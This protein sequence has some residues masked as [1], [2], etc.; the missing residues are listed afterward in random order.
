METKRIRISEKA[1]ASFYYLFMPELFSVREMYIFGSRK[2]AKTKNVALRFIL[3]IMHDA[4]YNAMA[5]RKSG[6]RIEESIKEELD[7]AIRELGVMHLFKYHKTKREYTYLPYKNRIVLRSITVSPETGKPTLSGL[8]VS[9]GTIKDVWL[10]EAWEFTEADYKMIRQ[11]VRGGIWTMLI[12][13]NPYFPSFWCVKRAIQLYR[14]H[15]DT[16]KKD[17]EM[18]AHIPKAIKDGRLESI[19]HWNNFQINTK[20]SKADIEE[21]WAE[22]KTNPKDFI[23]TGYGYPGSPDGTI[24]GDLVHLIKKR[25]MEYFITRPI[26]YAG[27][28]DIGLEHDAMT[29]SFSGLASTGEMTTAEGYFHSNG[30]QECNRYSDN[31][32]FRK[33]DPHELANDIIDY[34]IM[35]EPIWRRT[36]RTDFKVSVDSA[37]SAMVSILNR[38]LKNRGINEKWFRR[39]IGEDG[40]ID[41]ENRIVFE[42]QL[43]SRGLWSVLTEDDTMLA[44]RLLYE[45]E[46][47]PY[48]RSVQ[49]QEIKIERDGSRVHP[50]MT[51]AWEYSWRRWMHK[52][53]KHFEGVNND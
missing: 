8:N 39:T 29:A 30:A 4:E 41:I 45:V 35:W 5:M 40:K 17:G 12:I 24:L 13:G 44:T 46:N 22:E 10:E 26:E 38:E 11:T 47:I 33:K 2:S 51:N 25:D 28:V 15:L 7:W 16:L 31:G 6:N 48:K 14:P 1:V 49:T 18:W 36:N 27:G 9:Q 20:L 21:R 19:V 42:R 32:V 50:D 34:F 23:V 52:I 3:R 37:D 43:I 53:S